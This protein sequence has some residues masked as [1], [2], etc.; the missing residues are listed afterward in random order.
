MVV[1][2]GFS[3]KTGL[4]AA[5]E[6]TT[7]S[8]WV[9]PQEHTIT[10]STFSSAMRS[11]PVACTV[12]LGRPAA[13]LLGHHLVGVGDRDHLGPRDDLGEPAD[14]V[15]TDHAGTDDSDLERHVSFSLS[16]CCGQ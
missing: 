14:V 12:A 4:P 7:Y 13:D 16:W 2:S 3:Q 1:A 5:I 9:G 10:A 8:S 15:A 11:S 6:A